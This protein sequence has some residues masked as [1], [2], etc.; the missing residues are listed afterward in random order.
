ML[1]GSHSYLESALIKL[2][3]SPIISVQDLELANDFR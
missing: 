3:G 1:W 2:P